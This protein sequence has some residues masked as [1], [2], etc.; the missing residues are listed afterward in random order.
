MQLE[1][2]RIAAVRSSSSRRLGVLTALRW[3]IMR[4]YP[5][6]GDLFDLCYVSFS[7]PLTGRADCDTDNVDIL[8]I[9][10]I[11]HW[12]EIQHALVFRKQTSRRLCK[13]HSTFN[14]VHPLRPNLPQHV[15]SPSFALPVSFVASSLTRVLTS[16]QT[17]W[18]STSRTNPRKG[19]PRTARG[20]LRLPRVAAVVGQRRPRAAARCRAAAHDVEG[21]ETQGDGEEVLPGGE[22][23]AD[24]RHHSSWRRGDGHRPRNRADLREVHPRLR[25]V[26]GRDPRAVERDQGGGAEA[27]RHREETARGERRAGPGD[28]EGADCGHG[29]GQ[30]GMLRFPENHR[31]ASS[32]VRARLR[33]LL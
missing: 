23:A 16:L 33:W 4:L 15:H 18:L 8:D 29:A 32:R 12:H 11:V 9:N 24:E 1:D 6:R 22:E 13:A 2:H 27:A 28:G 14:E 31:D 19:G 3:I 21:E 10:V 5:G 20:G 30:G 25:R 26:G 17:Q 7:R